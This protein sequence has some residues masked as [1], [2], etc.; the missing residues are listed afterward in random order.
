MI[1]GF[2][3]FGLNI[4]F[5]GILISIGFIVGVILVSKLAPKKGFDSG[6]AFDLVLIVFPCAII[7]ARIGYVLFHLEKYP[8]F[9]SMLKVWEGGLMIYGGVLLSAIALLIYCKI[10]KY[11]FFRLCDLIVPA[12][13]LGQAIG[14]WGNFFNQEA[15]GSL[16]TNSG[17]QWFPFS[18]WIESSHFT[19]EAEQQLIN[20]YGTSNVAGAWF[21]A[22]FFYESFWCLIGFVLLMILTQ[23]TNKTGLL[24]AVY[25]SYYGFER[26]FVEMMRTDSLYLGPIKISVLLSGLFVVAGVTYLIYLLIQNKKE[27]GKQIDKDSSINTQKDVNNNANQT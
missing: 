19:P 12:L 5:Y 7:G 13:I 23:K 3:L 24:T 27:K 26:F 15:Y 8:T 6:I 16:V 20:A 4:S 11:N 10:K 1:N 22:T 18:V 9:V 25:F 14:R 17:F 2:S 21:N